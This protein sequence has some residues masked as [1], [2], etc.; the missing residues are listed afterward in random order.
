VYD[1]EEFFHDFKAAIDPHWNYNVYTGPITRSYAIDKKGEEMES[2]QA[3]HGAYMVLAPNVK[4]CERVGLIGSTD[5]EMEFYKAFLAVAPILGVEAS[6]ALMLPRQAPGNP[7][8]NEI[9]EFAKACDIVLLAA[10]HSL[11]HSETVIKILEAG[12][13]CITFPVPAGSRALG[14]LAQQAIYSKDKLFELK[15]N[16]EKVAQIFDKGREVHVT[17]KNGSEF[18]ANITDRTTHIWYGICEEGPHT[19]NFSSLPPGEAHVTSIEDS[20]EGV[21]VID[22]YISGVGMPITPVRLK[23]NKG[24][25]VNISGSIEARKLEKIMAGAGEN[26]YRVGE[27]GVGTNPYQP[28]VDSNG[29]KKATGT[30]HIGVGCNAS[31]CFGGVHYDGKNKSSIHIDLLLLPPVRVEV[32]GRKVVDEGK[33]LI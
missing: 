29:D 2:V 3:Y 4:P 1:R 14:V 15:A 23:I 5:V 10:S 33:L 16:S 18:S 20:G 9:E 27:V 12:R 32:D 6:L 22:G 28:I 8:P 13:K 25:V 26:S 31:P 11:A 30:F 17:C 7:A 24:K 21:L 19:H